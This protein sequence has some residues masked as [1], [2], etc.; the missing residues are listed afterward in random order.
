MEK[1]NKSL[2]EAISAWVK[3]S[4]EWEQIE[5]THSDRFAEKYP[6]DKDFHEVVR[7][8]MEW[9]EQINK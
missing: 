1:F 5:D 3:L 4:E 9:K 2:D 7:D 8:L 6:F